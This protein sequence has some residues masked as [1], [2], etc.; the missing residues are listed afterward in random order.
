MAERPLIWI[1]EAMLDHDPTHGVR[2]AHPES[3]DR[4]AVLL[5]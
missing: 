3:P 2:S 4:L 5:E 1:D